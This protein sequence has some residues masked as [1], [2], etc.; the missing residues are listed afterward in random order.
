MSHI[1][2][3]N[4]R[5]GVKPAKLSV[6]N[7]DQDVIRI[8]CENNVEFWLEF[9]TQTRQ[10]T[11][12]SVLLMTYGFFYGSNKPS[13]RVNAYES[14]LGTRFRILDDTEPAFSVEVTV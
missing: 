12:R 2:R 9:N 6:Q 1:V 14:P 7:V 5:V 4:G 11:G 3:I 8:E 13:Y 10:V